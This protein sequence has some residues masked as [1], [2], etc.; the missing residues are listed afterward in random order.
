MTDRIRICLN[1][2][3]WEPVVDTDIQRKGAAERKSVADALDEEA[4]L[5][6][7]AESYEFFR[8]VA[9]VFRENTIEGHRYCEGPGYGQDSNH[10]CHNNKFVAKNL[11]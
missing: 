5:S 1:C 9:E 2:I 4:A 6:L 8:D 11:S 10:P 3:H 7:S